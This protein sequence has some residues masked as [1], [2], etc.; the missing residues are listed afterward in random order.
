MADVDRSLARVLNRFHHRPVCQP[1]LVGGA[2]SPTLRRPQAPQV[3]V[4]G[5]FRR[6]AGAR[7]VAHPKATP[8][9]QTRS[10]VDASHPRRRLNR[11][12]SS[13]SRPLSSVVPPL[14]DI[15]P[16]AT[17]RLSNG[18]LVMTTSLR[19]ATIATLS[20]FVLF[21]G[22]ASGAERQ[23]RPGIPNARG[24]YTGCYSIA[25]GDLRLI[26]GWKGCRP[27][28]RRA[29]W[30][31][32]GQRGP[33]GLEGPEGEQ[34]GPGPAGPSGTQGASGSQGPPGA[35]GAPG[36]SGPSGAQGLQGDR[37]RR[38]CKAIPV[39]PERPANRGCRGSR[40][41]LARREPREP[42]GRPVQRVRRG[43]LARPVRPVRPAYRDRRALRDRRIRRCS[44]RCPARP[45]Q[46]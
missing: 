41:T 44:P 12:S 36:P 39:R 29:T 19:I 11:V 8:S 46:A 26:A 2:T 25:T 14:G 35:T 9:I 32:R 33:L 16:F 13:R 43:P 24:I 23:V 3:R 37:G 34:G 5:C 18:S 27:L 15:R 10:C 21:G 31:R 4:A 28:E 6:A 22:V 40:A 38:G 30:N 17:W 45:L 7:A 1:D 42:R 20:A